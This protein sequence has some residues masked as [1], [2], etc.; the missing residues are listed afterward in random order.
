VETRLALVYDGGV[1]AGRISLHRFVELVAT[2]PARLFGLFPRK[3]TVA[4]G[5]DADLVLF[6]PHREWTISAKTHHMRVDYNPYEGRT[7]RGRPTAVLSRGEVV[8]E[9]EKFVGRAGR[10]RFLKRATRSF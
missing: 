5:S 7:G 6:D 8:I 2:A 1:R 4:V 10:G 9:N 3:G